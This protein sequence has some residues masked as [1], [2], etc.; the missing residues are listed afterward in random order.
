MP[1]CAVAF[2]MTKKDLQIY[3]DKIYQEALA[4]S[5]ENE[6]P[7]AACLITDKNVYYA[8]NRVEEKNHPFKHAE[9]L[10]IEEALLKEKTRRLKNGVLIVS[11]EPCLMCLGALIKAGVK[12]LY[13]VLDD[14][15]L[16]ALSHY[17]A[18]VDDML[19]ITRLNDER[20]KELI[21]G[22]FLNLRKNQL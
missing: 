9:L 17:H 5:K 4:A 20:F 12:A 11:L 6:V 8:H 13:Y 18:F 3:L 2:I 1:Q 10:V 7:V 15:K 19:I 16:G 22:F 21:D 14:P